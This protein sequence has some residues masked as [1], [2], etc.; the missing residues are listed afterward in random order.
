[1]ARHTVRIRRQHDAK[2]V[3]RVCLRFHL[4]KSFGIHWLSGRLQLRSLRNRRVCDGAWGGGA[5]TTPKGFF[6]PNAGERP[7]DP[8]WLRFR[9]VGATNPVFF[10]MQ[11]RRRMEVHGATRE[12][13]AQVKVKNSHHAAL[14]P[15]AR[16]RKAYS[17]EEVTA[18]QVISDPL[19]LLDTCA[20]SDG[21]AAV[22]LSSLDFAKSRGCGGPA[23]ISGISLQTPTFPDTSPDLPYL[24][25]DSAASTEP[26]PVFKASIAGRAYDEAGIGPEDIDVAEVYDLSTAMELDWYEHIGLCNVGEAEDLLRSGDTQIGGKIPVNPSGGLAG[27]GEAPPAQALAQVC[28]LVWQVRGQA[29][30]RGVEGARAGIAANQGLFGHGSAVVVRAS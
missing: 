12:D 8:D 27:F 11:A 14:N 15:N 4:R 21:G 17:I 16:Y 6:A 28:E 2:R 7:D 20:T 9:L 1:M 26:G 10:A 29:G 24:A 25:T 13:F 18:S 30:D 5:D 19:R 23:R 22:V 3:P